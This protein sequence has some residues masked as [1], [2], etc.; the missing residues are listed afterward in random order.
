M[1]PYIL[2]GSYASYYTAK[3]RSY[4]R[5]KAIP[6]IERLPSDPLFRDKVRPSSGSHRIPQML[7]PNGD[8]VQDS[9]EIQDYCEQ[10]FPELPVIPLTT[11]QRC[12]VHLMELLASEGLVR[13]AWLH[14]WQFEEN[15]EFVINDFG[16]SFRPMGD[17]EELRKYGQL[18]AD[19]MKSYGLPAS[20]AEF[21]QNLDA[22]YSAFLKLFEKHLHCYPY[23][24]GGQPC[25][26]DHAMMG[27]LFAHL[28]RDPAGRNLMQNQAPRVFRW[29]EHM[30]TPE[31]QSPEFYD[32]PI[33]FLSD[34]EVPQSALDMMNWIASSY[35]ETFL[36]SSQAFNR[37]SLDKKLVA[38]YI[39]DQDK[40]QP[41]IQ[42]EAGA[43]SSINVHYIWMMQR[44]QLYYQSLGKHAQLIVDDW[45][46]PGIA[47]DLMK[48]PV[49]CR[50]TRANNRIVVAEDAK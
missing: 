45:L 16:R 10:L 8:V 36:K 46:K 44:S 21:R 22:Q 6:F 17:D 37:F 14:R 15:L 12:Y 2:F 28:G 13:L 39:F 4:L 27:A 38:G 5:K 35:G 41:M 43:H 18:I 33:N 42:S 47:L 26:A 50:L 24:L 20:T 11:K 32:V 30:N 3:S 23:L 48:Q 31:I 29:V 40:D 49:A 34:D 9:V 25:A 7:A 1:Q 19:R